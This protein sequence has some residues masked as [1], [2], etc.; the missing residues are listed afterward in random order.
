MTNIQ[1]WC[2]SRQLWWGH[3]IPAWYKG[4]EV[5]VGMEPPKGEGWV[6]DSDVLDTWFSSALWPFSTLGWPNDTADLKR[7]F[8]NNVLVTGY[9]IIFFWVSRMIFESLEFTKQRPFKE[10]LIHGLIRDKQGRKMS[11]SLGNGVDPMDVIDQYGADALRF[12]LTTNSSPGQDLRYDEDKVKSSWNFIN[13]LW[14]ASRFVLM[15][16]EDF[17]SDDYN[18]NDL[19]IYDKWIMYRLNET[20]K[21]VRK[22]MDKYEFN[23]VGNALYNFIWNDF[24]D[25]YIELSKTNLESNTTKSVLLY[26]LTSILKMLHPFMPYVTEEIYQML[27][28]KDISI[29]V[30]EYPQ[31]DKSIKFNDEINQVNKIIDIITKVRMVK[32]ENNIGKD[33]YLMSKLDEENTK[34]IEENEDILEKL[35]KTKVVKSFDDGMNNL[36]VTLPYGTL[37]LG[38]ISE[39]NIEEEIANLNKELATLQN[40]IERRS[41]LLANPGYVS[42]APQ[43]IVEA[44]KIKLE[45]EKSRLEIVQNRLREYNK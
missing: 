16:L 23:V 9:D 31:V 10:V 17:K 44:E 36:H 38:F 26:T 14:N 28:E 18:F 27:P 30:S 6:Q 40:N 25:W 20:I 2:I 11:K 3:Q 43:N 35:L 19:S 7:Y 41:K 12:F 1:D 29:L 13:K 15:N 37:V 5:Y 33:Y 8:P 45:E 34:I 32:Q 42:K 22:H 24:C 39:V 21:L 4:E